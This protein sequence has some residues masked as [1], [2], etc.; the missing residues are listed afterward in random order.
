[1]KDAASAR[2]FLTCAALAGAMA[3][4]LGAFGAHALKARLTPDML[5]EFERGK[6]DFARL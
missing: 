3:V 2:L 4:M 5:A 1:M 6:E